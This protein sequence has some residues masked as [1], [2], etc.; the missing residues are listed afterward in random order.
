MLMFEA[1]GLNTDL[2]GSR[3]NAL[4][5]GDRAL[6]VARDRETG[7]KSTGIWY[8]QMMTLSTYAQSS[9]LIER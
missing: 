8:G 5:P 6:D 9:S 4:Y 3:L 1:V 2:R 7:T